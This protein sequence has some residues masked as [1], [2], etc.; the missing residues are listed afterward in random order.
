[1]RI[2]TNKRV[3]GKNEFYRIV[4]RYAQFSIGDVEYMWS[5]I[6]QVFAIAIE[7]DAILD[8]RG[9]GRLYV[10]DIPEFK[11]WDGVNKKYITKKGSKRVV[12]KLAENIKNSWKDEEENDELEL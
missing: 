3:I 8:L 11:G 7:E 2:K 10:K 9:F 4:A 6:E 1:M 12:F 5:V